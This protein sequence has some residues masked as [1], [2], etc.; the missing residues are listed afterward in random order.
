VD[1]TGDYG[2]W[3][4]DGTVSGTKK[5]TGINGAYARGLDPDNTIIFN[6]RPAFSGVDASGNNGLLVSNGTAGGTY[7]H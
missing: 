3:A 1:A 2:L 6:G 5:L 7:S 4:T